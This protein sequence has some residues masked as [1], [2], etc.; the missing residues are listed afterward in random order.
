MIMSKTFVQVGFSILLCLSLFYCGCPA[1]PPSDVW[2]ETRF[3]VQRHDLERIVA[4][5]DQDPQ[6]S[7]IAANFLW[8][9]DKVA[10]PRPESE[11]GIS[12]A[13]W[14]DYRKLFKQA[15]FADGV[16]RGGNDVKVIEWSWGIVAGGSLSVICIA[17]HHQAILP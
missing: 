11:W 2:L 7:R 16:I 4:M 12:E 15:H 17:A 14:D 6:M 10:W 5:S 9:Q 13:R 1:I 3:K 8:T